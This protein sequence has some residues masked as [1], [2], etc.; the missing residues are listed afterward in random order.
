[1]RFPCTLQ[2]TELLQFVWIG[3]VSTPHINEITHSDLP[4]PQIWLLF[5]P[6]CAQVDASSFLCL[7]NNPLYPEHVVSLIC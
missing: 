4:L 3:L 1:M 2:T 7:S 5:H 6:L